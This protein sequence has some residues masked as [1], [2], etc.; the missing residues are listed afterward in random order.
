M[1]GSLFALEPCSKSPLLAT[2]NV[3][4]VKGSQWLGVFGD[5]KLLTVLEEL[6]DRGQVPTVNELILHFSISKNPT[7]TGTIQNMKYRAS[8]EVSKE[9][10]K[11]FGEAAPAHS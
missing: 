5:R 8:S 6:D 10:Q 2:A 1:R 9:R 3:E 4:L 11:R 7:E